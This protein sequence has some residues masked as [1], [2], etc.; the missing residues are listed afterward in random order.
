MEG[1]RWQGVGARVRWG[2]VDGGG[3]AAARKLSVVAGMSGVA[4][5]RCAVTRGVAPRSCAGKLCILTDIIWRVKALGALGL[6]NCVLDVY[7]GAEIEAL[8]E[9]CLVGSHRLSRMGVVRE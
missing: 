7:S 4:R 2:G 3:C 1:G 6:G 8:L 5:E 9:I